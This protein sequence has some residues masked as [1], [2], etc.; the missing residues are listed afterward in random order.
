MRRITSVLFSLIAAG[1]AAGAGAAP[2]PVLPAPELLG[3]SEAATPQARKAQLLARSRD[4][5]RTA[6]AKAPKTATVDCAKGDSLQAAID[7]HPGD[8]TLEVRG[9]C[10]ENVRVSQR[11]LTLHGLDPATDGI[12]GVAADP[13]VNAALEVWYSELVRIENLSISHPAGIGL[14]LWFSGVE[15]HN[16]RMVANARAGIHVSLSSF[17]DGTELILSNNGRAGLNVQRNSSAFCLG[18][19]LENNTTWAAVS[20]SGSLL[21]VLDGVIT[22]GRGLQSLT[23]SYADID[24]VTEDSPYPCSLNVSRTAAFAIG[25]ATAALYGAGPFAGQLFA[26]DRGEIYLYGAQQTST[27]VGPAGNPLPN[28]VE[29]FSTLIAEPYFDATD[30]AHQSQ[31]AGSTQLNTFSRALLLDGTVVNGTLSCASAGDAW[32][33]AGVTVSGSPIS[34]C[35]HVPPAPAP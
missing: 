25:D 32:A 23:G 17:L 24:C 2:P 27:G 4:L 34:G 18:C 11:K 31:L 15:A 12:R 3:P 19:R 21:S 6:P 14:G 22:G 20:N 30:T 13:P 9:L 35:D 5:R 28:I 33:D 10:N 1:L 29:Y 8:V 7:Q 16:C 26:N